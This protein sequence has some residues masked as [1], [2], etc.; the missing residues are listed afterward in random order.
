MLKRLTRVLAIGF[1]L[2]LLQ[3]L[4]THPTYAAQN[5]SVT[6]WIAKF[7]SVSEAEWREAEANLARMGSVVL[8]ELEKLAEGADVELQ[9]RIKD[10]VALML[11]KT[12]SLE[13]FYQYKTIVVLSAPETNRAKALT[14]ILKNAKEYDSGA[15]AK[16]L[17][18]PP[19]SDV[20]KAMSQVVRFG[21]FAVPAAVELTNGDKPASRLYGAEL[22]RMV[23]ATGQVNIFEKL[24][25]DSTRIDVD[26]GDYISHTTVGE[27]I[28]GWIEDIYPIDKRHLPDPTYAVCL[29]AAQYVHWL[30]GKGGDPHHRRITSQLV[31]RLYEETQTCNAT[32]WED[33]W[34]R[35][36]PILREYY[37]K[38]SK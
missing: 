7:Q 30:E 29:E 20:R 5:P 38:G 32:S 1:L 22:I 33:Y 37:D 14:E 35:A 3:V 17:S 31:N 13:E 28:L 11:L 21:G 36:R 8:P 25:K 15:V 4:F 10:T 27:V 23:Q 26:H 19:P 6:K 34:N 16:G 24:R 12:V 18:V 9:S 2:A